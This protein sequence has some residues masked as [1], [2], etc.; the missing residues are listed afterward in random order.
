M[1]AH[2]HG[3][4]LGSTVLTTNSSGNATGGEGYY[5]YGRFRVGNEL[6]TE[7]RFT[8]QKLDGVGLQYFNARYYDPEL[9][10][11]IS[12]DTIVPDPSNLF[13]YNRYMYVRGN[14]LRFNDPSGHCA[15]LEGGAPDIE[16]DAGCWEAAREVYGSWAA[17]PKYWSGGWDI[18]ADDWF[19]HIASAEYATEEWIQA[20]LHHFW[21]PQYRE[22]GVHHTRYNP[23]PQMHPV[24]NQ[25]QAFEKFNAKYAPDCTNKDCFTQVLDAGATGAS[26]VTSACLYTGQL[27]CAGVATVVGTGLTA[28]GTGR[29]VAVAVENPT[30]A[31][32]VDAGVAVVTAVAGSAGGAQVK[33]LVGVGISAFQWGYDYTDFLK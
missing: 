10:Q 9:G 22:W 31:N 1:L 17:D 6:G 7:N 16:N 25:D 12:P 18:T 28:W 24:T 19:K 3:D 8:G 11:F 33:G 4:Q 15:V 21:S 26:V 29:T 14:P 5:A 23:R 32:M 20:K 13:D 30:T 27:P 2:V